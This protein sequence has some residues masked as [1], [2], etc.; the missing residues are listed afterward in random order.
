MQAGWEPNTIALHWYNG[1][2]ELT[3]PSA[4]QSCV[5]DGTLTPPTTIPTKTGYTFKGWHVRPTMNFSE[6]PTA[7]NGTNRWAIGWYNNANYCWYDTNTGNASHVA[8]NSDATFSEE[9]QTYEWKV[10]Y[11]HGELYGMSGCSTTDGT[12][13]TAGNPTIGSGKYCWCKATGYKANG[14]SEV[15]GPLSALSWVFSYGSGSVMYCAR[16]CAKRCV[17]IAGTY[18]EFRGALFAPA[19]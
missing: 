4:S 8:C 19:Q 14:S 3:V 1:D 9:L 12:Y 5:Y 2:D 10:K 17:T 15:K 16:D 18:S 7:A 6:I 11:S 13:A